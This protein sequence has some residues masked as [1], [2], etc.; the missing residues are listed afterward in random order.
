LAK[1]DQSLVQIGGTQAAIAFDRIAE[2]AGRQGVSLAQVQAMFPEYEASL[3]ETARSLG[4]N[5]LKTE[6]YAEWMRG[7][8][9]AAIAAAS[10][11]HPE[12]V[13]K[14]TDVQQAALGGA[15]SLE[16]YVKSLFAAANAALA[17]SGSQ[18][19]FERTMDNTTTAVKKL[20]AEAKKAGDFKNLTNIGTEEGRKGIEILNGLATAATS[21]ASKLITAQ[22]PQEEIRLAMAR[23]RAEFI[24]SAK[25][26]GYSSKE[27]GKL[28]D[29]R[30]LIPE[31][32]TVTTTDKGTAQAKARADALAESIK[33]LPKSAQTTVES[34]FKRGGI[35]AAYT[36]LRK[37]DKTKADAFIR[38]ILDK[39]GINA[40]GK[41][42]PPDKNAYI[43]TYTRQGGGSKNVRDRNRAAGGPVFGPGTETSDTIPAMLSNNEHV[44]SAAE[45]R[46]AGGHG[47][48]EHLRSLSLQGKMPKFR[49]GGRVGG[50]DYRA[51]RRQLDTGSP[52]GM[53]QEQVTVAV[54]GWQQTATSPAVAP[55]PVVSTTNNY[56]YLGE[57]YGDS[58]LDRMQRD[59]S[60]ERART[61]DR[62]GLG[63][64]T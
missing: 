5:N 43:N 40:W 64:G 42:D 10:A 38:S 8:I 48:M 13:G 3:K 22:A 59:R 36:A 29:A 30:G 16:D 45:V 1:V 57:F 31:D 33:D 60:A 9:P 63:V 35:E 53:S 27:A 46:A 44:W 61:M 18:V 28:A 7:K 58:I 47:V 26:M 2:S 4:V 51:L 19:G 12:L 62:Y 50:D 24:E 32:I 52:S 23:A 17:V 21:Y 15:Q 34:E 37:I 20:V 14:L 55:S 6:E 54:R 56:R 49:D 39:S 25:A 11:A 41:Y